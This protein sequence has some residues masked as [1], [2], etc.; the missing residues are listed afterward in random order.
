LVFV[1]PLL[2][3]ACHQ[4]GPSGF[5]RIHTSNNIAIAVEYPSRTSPFFKAPLGAPGWC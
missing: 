2:A 3:L 1:A 4:A 5:F